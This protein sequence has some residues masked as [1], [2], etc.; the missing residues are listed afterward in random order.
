M[1]HGPKR[2]V[3]WNCYC[4]DLPLS[5]SVRGAGSELRTP[6]KQFEIPYQR[7]FNEKGHPVRWPKSLYSLVGGTRIELVTP[8]V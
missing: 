3:E 7:P 2:Q 1:K 6:S 5:S 4:H 8:A